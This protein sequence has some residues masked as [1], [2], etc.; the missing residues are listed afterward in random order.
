MNLNQWLDCIAEAYK[1]NG[2]SFSSPIKEILLKE[3]P[4]TDQNVDI[5]DRDAMRTGVIWIPFAIEDESQNAVIEETKELMIQHFFDKF[6]RS[7]TFGPISKVNNYFGQTVED[8]YELEGSPFI[9]MAKTYWTFKLELQEL[10]PQYNNLIVSQI[11][12]RVENFIGSIFFPY[13]GP[14]ILWVRGRREKQKQ[15][16]EQ[17][18]PEVDIDSF[19]D[20]N[21][22]L[23]TLDGRISK[24]VFNE[25]IWTSCPNSNCLH[26]F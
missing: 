14:I 26:F 15:L 25:R 20:N 21:P 4:E 6:I 12:L 3:L 22:L 7:E 10:F 11:L 18:A 5:I 19:L 8:N 16:I 9:D 13:P 2:K 24:E 1:K 23:G 17:Y